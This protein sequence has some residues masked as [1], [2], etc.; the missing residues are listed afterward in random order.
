MSF[1][2]PAAAGLGTFADALDGL[3]SRGW[4][5]SSCLA[6]GL[7]VTLSSHSR[8]TLVPVQGAFMTC[9]PLALLE[10]PYPMHARL[11]GHRA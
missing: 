5:R 7:G 4:A 3:M 9:T 1:Q 2:P 11:R 8:H 10:P 6:K